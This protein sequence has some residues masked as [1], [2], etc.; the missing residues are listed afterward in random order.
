MADTEAPV[1]PTEPAGPS[2]YEEKAPYYGKR[3]ELFE[4]YFERE[5]AKVEEAKSKNEPIK[6]VMPDGAIKEGIKFP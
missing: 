4:K 6:V 3:I 1:A 2:P 5:G